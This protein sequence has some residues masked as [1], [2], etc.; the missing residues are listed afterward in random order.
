MTT[1]KPMRKTPEQWWAG[2][3][4]ADREALWKIMRMANDLYE[5][6]LLLI[7]YVGGA[8]VASLQSDRREVTQP[9]R[10]GGKVWPGTENPEAWW[11]GRSWL[12]KEWLQGQAQ[13]VLDLKGLPSH[14]M[15]FVR[16]GLVVYSGLMQHVGGVA[17][18]N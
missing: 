14:A 7:E 3:E 16:R 1:E 9:G 2:L 10:T 17:P 18:L 12:S 8:F 15:Q 5:G 11:A 4:P 6:E 13:K